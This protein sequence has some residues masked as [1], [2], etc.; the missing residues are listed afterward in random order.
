MRTIRVSILNNNHGNHTIWLLWL[1]AL[2]HLSLSPGSPAL[3][4]LIKPSKDTACLQHIQSSFWICLRIFRISFM[5]S[6]MISSFLGGCI[7][8]I[9]DSWMGLN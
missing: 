1:L 8:V 2:V 6:S 5:T 4:I 3:F 7:L 9:A